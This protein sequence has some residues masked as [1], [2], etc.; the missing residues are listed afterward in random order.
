MVFSAAFH[1]GVFFGIGHHPPPPKRVVVDDSIAVN[2][3]MP[4]LKEL[5]EPD[6]VSDQ[7]EPPADLGLSVPTLADVPTQVDLSEAFVQQID[8]STLVPQQDLKAAAT[9]SIP[10]HISRGTKLG[11][12]MGKIFDLKDLDRAPEPL[13]KIA[14]AVPPGLRQSGTHVEMSVLFVVDP[15]GVVRNPEILRSS[16]RR[17]E[18]AALIAISKWKFRPGLKGGRRVNVRMI[19]PLIF[20]VREE[21]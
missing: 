13:V 17:F 21:E 14:P 20:D 7:E 5:E 9:I 11:E 16:D 6:R 8:Y 18:D 2:F 10:T 3:V 4:D 12:G 19:Q 15:N 1:G